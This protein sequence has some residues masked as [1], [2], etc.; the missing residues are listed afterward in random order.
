MVVLLGAVFTASIQVAPVYAATPAEQGQTIFEQKCKSCHT[1][2]SGRL[3]GPDLKGVTTNRD[4]EW[5]ISFITTP[6]KLIAQGDP[7][8]QQMVQQYGLPMPNLGISNYDAQAIL[9]YIDAQ[10]AGNKPA[11]TPA[12]TQT[13]TVTPSVTT[14]T[15]IGNAATGK[16]LFT[17]KLALKNGGPAC[18]SCHN[19]SSIG[20]I[21]GGT[22]GKD[23]TTAYSKLSEAG[24]TSILK[25]TPFP[26]MKEI[27]TVKPLTDDEI[28]GISAFLKEAGFVPSATSQNPSLFFIIGGTGSL[29]IIG[30]FQWLWRGRLAGVRRPLVKGGSK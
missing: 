22:V 11:S 29:V 8:A 1:I 10:S 4:M 17:G 3:V 2:G 7:I 30:L 18:L 21:G 15:V 24:I 23:L 16:D 26:L 25:T 12:T 13:T 28:A 27:Y 9:A 19:V 20:I 6:D 5:L 14:I